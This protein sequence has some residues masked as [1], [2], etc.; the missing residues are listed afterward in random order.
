M[1]IAIVSPFPDKARTHLTDMS[2]V[3]PYTELLVQHELAQDPTADITVLTDIQTSKEEYT[4]SVSPGADITVKRCYRMG[5][6]SYVRLLREITSGQYDV[7]H[8]Q[9]ETFLFGGILSLLA[10]PFFL[11]CARLSSFIIVTLH[12][13]VPQKEV[14]KTFTAVFQTPIPLTF[15]RAGFWFVYTMIGRTAQCLVVHE[16]YFQKVLATDYKVSSK[17]IRVIHHGVIDPTTGI[18]SDRPSLMNTFHVP[19][20][21]QYVFGFFGY[22]SKFKGLDYLMR[23]FAAHLQRFPN[24]VLIIAGALHPHY[25]TD[26]VYRE[27]IHSLQDMAKRISNRIIW[28]GELTSDQIGQFYALVDCIILPYRQL[29]S[30]SSILSAAIGSGKQFLTSDCLRPLLTDEA[31]TFS[32]DRH[33]LH[34]KLDAFTADTGC[35]HHRET[36]FLREQKRS[37]TWDI[38][39]KSTLH[40]YEQGIMQYGR[41]TILLTGAY[42]QTNLGDEYMLDRCLETLPSERCIVLSAQPSKTV[43]DHGVSAVPASAF[44]LRTFKAF[45]DC[46]TVIVGGGDQFKLL[47]HSTGHGRYALLLKMAALACVCRIWRKQLVFLG[48][49][50]GNIATSAARALTHFSLSSASFVG[51]RDEHSQA[52]CD[53][54]THQHDSWYGADVAFL[55]LPDETLIRG[56]HQRTLGIAPAFE[57]EHP[58]V[59]ERLMQQIGK[60]AERLLTEQPGVHLELLPFQPAYHQHPD[61]KSCDEILSQITNTGRCALRTDLTAETASFLYRELGLLWGIRLHSLILACLYEVPFI[62]LVYDDKVRNFLREIHCEQW[63]IELDDTFTAER[64]LSKHAL[65]LEHRQEMSRHLREQKMILHQRATSM[66]SSFHSILSMPTPSSSSLLLVP[67]DPFLL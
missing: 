61:T 66:L 21:A 7:V 26:P 1:R 4:T 18:T 30:T 16:E 50:I 39:A 19:Q 55:R 45:L 48:I 59:Y 64:L 31:L 10:F 28:Q 58:A 22:L 24:S 34:E 23:E 13:V 65:L 37:R 51:L 56:T 46:D 44:S 49:G 11:A 43:R 8:V 62:A 25:A 29:T 35:M 20:D 17:K 12:H 6:S 32:F 41:K 57:I 3:A 27:Y 2:A 9:H 63:G 47:K 52:V 38:V 14:N 67:S 5:I 42:G 36:D 53:A 54:L 33:D 40:A 15:I 60:A